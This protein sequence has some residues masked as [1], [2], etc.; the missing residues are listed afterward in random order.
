MKKLS[1]HYRTDDVTAIDP[2]MSKYLDEEYLPTLDNLDAVNP[3]VLVVFSGG[4][5]TGKSGLSLRIG[6]E[7]QGVVIE[8]DAIKRAILRKI[9][10]I[11]RVKEIFKLSNRNWRIQ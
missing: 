1:E 7:L 4:N 6:D 3:K 9:P 11:D 8:N 2:E 5:A 10:D